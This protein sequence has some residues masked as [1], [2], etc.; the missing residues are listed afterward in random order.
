[1][2]IDISRAAAIL[3]DG[4]G[5]LILTHRR[6]DGDTLGSAAALCSALRR[7]GKRAALYPNGGV[8]EKY[9]PFVSEYIDSEVSGYTAPVSVDI[10]GENLFPL[11]WQGNVE[12]AID[13][14]PSN[15]G[16]ASET[17]LWPGRAACGEIVLELIELLCGG[18]TPQEADLLYIAVSTDCGCFQYANTSA[19]TFR[20]AARLL[21]AGADIQR[22]N[23][24]LFRS[25]SPARLRLE[26]MIYSTLRSY[27][28]NAINIAV[29]TE[30]M[31]R[32]SGAGENDMDDIAALP[33]RV[34]GS[35][36]SA[37]I[38]ERTDGTSKVSLRSTD[39][40]DS[41]SICAIFGGGGHKMAAGC[42]M[43]CPPEEAAE[44]L[45][46]EIERAMG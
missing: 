20:S 7:L 46:R 5:F 12:L 33:G 2:N 40:L 32:K 23:K 29:I 39:A 19:D 28:N 14:H 13:H 41:S 36:V 11:G 10:A 8:T 17:L 37:T 9:A 34:A 15:S 22:L 42:E 3:R 16:F 1:M 31:I 30:E 45:L 21:E 38:K 35:V 44:K 25:V 18:I 26:G 27:R 43:D 6:P 4:D 24:L